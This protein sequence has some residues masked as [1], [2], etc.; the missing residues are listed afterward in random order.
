MSREEISSPGPGY[1]YRVTFLGAG[2]QGDV[3]EL[4]VAALGTSHLIDGVKQSDHLNCTGFRVQD[5]NHNRST[6]L[7]QAVVRTDQ[8][9][10]YLTPGTAYF[11]RVAA[12][13]AVGIGPAQDATPVSVFRSG[14]A[15]APQAP[16]GLPT[17]VRVYA[18]K[19]DGQ[20][21]RVAWAAV[22]DDNGAPVARYTLEYTPT[23]DF[24]PIAYELQEVSAR[25]HVWSRFYSFVRSFVRSFDCFECSFLLHTTATCRF[26]CSSPLNLWPSDILTV[27]NRCTIGRT[28]APKTSP[29]KTLQPTT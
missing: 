13:N 3:P 29:R 7:A 8:D 22:D 5:G 23:D 21:L 25:A 11:V 9:G 18:N 6:V 2:V 16:P 26:H 4:T 15:L 24:A 27:A 17:Q 20:S 14:N 10:G 19:D 12:R 1:E 28:A